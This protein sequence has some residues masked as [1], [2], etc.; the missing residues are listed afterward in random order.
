V[1]VSQSSQSPLLGLTADTASASGVTVA[2]PGAFSTIQGLLDDT[3]GIHLDSALP[4]TICP[5]VS[6]AVDQPVKGVVFS[7]V[8]TPNG[9]ST[10]RRVIKN[11][12]VV[13]VFN[14]VSFPSP[15]G[16][17][18]IGT[19]PIDLNSTVLNPLQKQLVGALD[20][21][22]AKIN[23][24]LAT[25]NPV[26][27]GLNGTL[28]DI[29]S[30]PGVTSGAPSVSVDKFDLLKCVTETVSD[31]YNPPSGEGSAA[32]VQDV[33]ANAA[34]SGDPVELIRIGVQPCAAAV[35]AID[36][37]RL[38]NCI[39]AAGA[40]AANVANKLTGLYDVPFLDVTSVVIKQV[41]TDPTNFQALAVDATQASGAF[42]SVL[43]RSTTDSTGRAVP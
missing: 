30:V 38:P 26:I 28:S 35:T 31:L 3:L 29:P 15:T 9:R 19:Q 27:Q 25:A 40:T 41:G 32:T 4:N 10:A 11:A 39:Q 42:R 23:S 12:V 8:S 20:A 7:Q 33:L 36:I 16:I 21:L 22:D 43:V 37:Y 18:S 34:A 6:V 2:V 24:T 13:P 17:G 5:Q 1:V 14:G